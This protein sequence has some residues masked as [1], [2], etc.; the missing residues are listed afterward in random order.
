MWCAACGA[1]RVMRCV[2]C[3]A[4]GMRAC[5]RMRCSSAISSR[6]LAI[7]ALFCS[8]LPALD[9]AGRRPRGSLPRLPRLPE[10]LMGEPEREP[11]RESYGKCGERVGSV[12]N[13]GW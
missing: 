6:S 11:E 8:L 4:C 1:L 2:W 3:A 5:S 9:E 10:L 7:C 12:A 13:G